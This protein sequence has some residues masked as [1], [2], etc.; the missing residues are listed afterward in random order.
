[1]VV[2]LPAPF[3]PSSP[4]SSPS[5]IEKEMSS[6]AGHL[7]DGAP[8]H[9][10]IRFEHTPK[11]CDFNCAHDSPCRLKRNAILLQNGSTGLISAAAPSLP[12]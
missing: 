2:V 3:G 4:K 5:S 12:M 1:M 6:T 11:I 8:D 9:A 10:H 7:L